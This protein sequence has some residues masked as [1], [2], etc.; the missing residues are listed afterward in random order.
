MSY[1]DLKTLMAF[2]ALL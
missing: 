1:G 2:R